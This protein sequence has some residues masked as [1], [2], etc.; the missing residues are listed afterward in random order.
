MGDGMVIDY[1]VEKLRNAFC[2]FYNATGININLVKP[3][4]TFLDCNPKIHNKYCEYIQSTEAGRNA[5]RCSDIALLEK[6]RI[7]EKPEM[8]ICHAGLIDIAVPIFHGNGLLGYIIFG[9]IKPSEET[10]TSNDNPYYSM[11]SHTEKERVSSIMS[12][13]VMLSKYIL[14]ENMLRPNV[15]VVLDAAL[16]YI[17][18][19]LDGNLTIQTISKA[20]HTSKGVLYKVFR[21][22]FGC[23]VNEQINICR[24]E[25]SAR[26]LLES[27]MSLEEISHRVGY[28]TSSYYTRIFK[29]IKG[30]TPLKY[31]KAGMRR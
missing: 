9:Q 3:D 17:H 27:D 15:D 30:T 29:K 1:D 2:D 31:R 7:S 5:C 8:H 28:C 21:N 14:L 12:L 20:T 13:A 24:I 25:E 22:H 18:N 16:E 4:F 11:L 19:N 26:L 10:L 6:C 23:T